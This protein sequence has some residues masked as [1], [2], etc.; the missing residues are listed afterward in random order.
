M[1]KKMI[2]TQEARL[3]SS[4]SVP[5]RSLLAASCTG[6]MGDRKMCG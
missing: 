3:D 4:L 1:F 2:I 6:G 5:L